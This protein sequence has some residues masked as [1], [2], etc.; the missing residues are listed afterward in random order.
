MSPAA[1]RKWLYRL[2]LAEIH[3]EER[4]KREDENAANE[5]HG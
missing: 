5:M 3:E 1:N 2:A 4:K